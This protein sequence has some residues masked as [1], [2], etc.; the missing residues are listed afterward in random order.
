MNK[1][2]DLYSFSDGKEESVPRYKRNEQPIHRIKSGACVEGCVLTSYHVMS[3]VDTRSKDD[4]GLVDL[5][6]V[7]VSYTNQGGEVLLKRLKDHSRFKA[8]GGAVGRLIAKPIYTH[9]V[10]MKELT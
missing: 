6:E 3:N 8:H 7:G 9:A 4:P 1:K 5:T 2:P 10:H